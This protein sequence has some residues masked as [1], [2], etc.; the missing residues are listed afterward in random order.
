MKNTA[1]LKTILSESGEIRY[2]LTTKLWAQMNKT[3][4]LFAEVCGI[5]SNRR[6]ALTTFSITAMAVTQMKIH[7]PVIKSL[8]TK[9][10]TC[11]FRHHMQA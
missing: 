7:Q 3:F 1:K 10:L 5:T 4:K 6:L 2:H 9:S 11:L 8:V